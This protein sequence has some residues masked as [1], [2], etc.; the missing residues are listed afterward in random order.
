ME[1]ELD[2]WAETGDSFYL[3]AV[4]LLLLFKS[5]FW[6][7][8]AKQIEISTTQREKKNLNPPMI[9]W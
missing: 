6:A 7:W 5:S 1:S 8:H 4:N 9:S 2:P 3:I